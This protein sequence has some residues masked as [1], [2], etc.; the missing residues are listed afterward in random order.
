MDIISKEIG[1]SPCDVKKII[2]QEKSILEKWRK[3]AT[4]AYGKQYQE[5]GSSIS[6]SN[7]NF[8][9][10][11][12]LTGRQSKRQIFTVNIN[13]DP[14]SQLLSN[15]CADNKIY[16]SISQNMYT[17]T[18]VKIGDTIDQ[19]STNLI[20]PNTKTETN[21]DGLHK[22]SQSK[23]HITFKNRS[24]DSSNA[25]SS[26]HLGQMSLKTDNS[27]KILQT[28]QAALNRLPK[29]TTYTCHEGISSKEHVGISD[30]RL[31]NGNNRRNVQKPNKIPNDQNDCL[32][33][34]EKLYNLG[35]YHNLFQDQTN[36]SS[37]TFPLDMLPNKR[38][39]QLSED[40]TC[41]IDKSRTSKDHNNP[42][43]T[44]LYN[45]EP[46]ASQHD[47]THPNVLNKDYQ[48]DCQ[49][50][51]HQLL[52][53]W[54]KRSLWNY[55][56]KLSANRIYKQIEEFQ[57]IFNVRKYQTYPYFWNDYINFQSKVQDQISA[58]GR[59]HVYLVDHQTI[60]EMCKTRIKPY[61]Y[62]KFQACL[63][64]AK[65]VINAIYPIRENVTKRNNLHGTKKCKLSICENRTKDSQYSVKFPSSCS[66]NV[67]NANVPESN[68][69]IIKI[70]IIDK[71]PLEYSIKSTPKVKEKVTSNK[72][73]R[74]AVTTL[75]DNEAD[76][77]NSVDENDVVLLE[78]PI[79]CI[80][81]TN[82]ALNQWDIIDLDEGAKSDEALNIGSII[83]PK[84]G[85]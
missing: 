26:S 76:N 50:A 6:Q 84:S 31:V 9:I 3:P 47:Q 16:P 71:A 77:I 34:S 2:S 28:D 11:N 57:R 56:G 17:S 44:K 45:K 55:K 62:E 74:K 83:F 5:A 80:D 38:T 64:R 66:K 36:N 73:K 68:S 52:I 53:E 23:R 40:V 13:K 58:E 49:D 30:S 7:I 19:T 69:R 61:I 63:L 54:T 70:T 65:E 21:H 35:T 75:K 67:K 22:M 59:F 8:K 10:N 46:I 33:P 72:F 20:I 24:S 42:K 81:V 1:I 29:D 41:Y 25:Y 78:K 12:I 60:V 82:E 37:I 85:K 43:C 79:E 18:F 48:S 39:Y 4:V 51:I 32:V 15:I 27:Q 14:G